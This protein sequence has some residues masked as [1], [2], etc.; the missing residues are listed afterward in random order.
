MKKRAKII[1]LLV[2]AVV[3]VIFAGAYFTYKQWISPT[4]I[5]F[6]N[7]PDYMFAKFDSA[8]DNSFIRVER[9]NWKKG[10]ETD[11]KKY[12]AVYIF[13][14]GLRLPPEKVTALKAAVNDSL[15]VYVYAA[16]F[17]SSSRMSS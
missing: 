9:I 11:L 15:A 8:N 16:T 14:M 1:Q 5:G 4:V 2:L 6:I 13:G 12:D 17:L 10:E 3:F 7:Y